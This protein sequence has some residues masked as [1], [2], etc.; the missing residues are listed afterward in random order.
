MSVEEEVISEIVGGFCLLVGFI[1]KDI[2]EIV[3]Y[4]V[5]KI[6]G[7]WIFEDEFEKMNI[8]LVEWGGVIFSVF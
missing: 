8:F 7:L 6:V 2:L 4:M 5:K 3:D 1:Y